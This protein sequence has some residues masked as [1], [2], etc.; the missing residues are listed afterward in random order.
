MADELLP[1]SIDVGQEQGET[2]GIF[3]EG[4]T[5]GIEIGYAIAVDFEADAIGFAGVFEEPGVALENAL[6]AGIGFALEAS[7]DG[8]QAELAGFGAVG[9]SH[10][11]F[12][13]GKLEAERSLDMAD[14]FAV[15]DDVLEQVEENGAALIVVVAGSG[16]EA[17]RSNAVGEGVGGGGGLAFWGFGAGGFEAVLVIGGE[18]FFGGGHGLFFLWGKK[19]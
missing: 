2:F 1:S 11:P 12:A 15:C 16:D 3:E 17:E 10:A 18:L 19:G 5:R 14:G 4:G 9:A 7:G 8:I 13:D 6:G